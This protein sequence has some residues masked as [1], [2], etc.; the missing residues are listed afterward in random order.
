MTNNI[1][2]GDNLVFYSNFS[3]EELLEL[4]KEMNDL[5]IKG[6]DFAIEHESGCIKIYIKHERKGRYKLC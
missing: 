2:F 4:S 3:Y 1:D 5:V 6:I